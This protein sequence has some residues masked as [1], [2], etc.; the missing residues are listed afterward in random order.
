[1]TANGLAAA[2]W[3]L[4]NTLSGLALADVRYV[5]TEVELLTRELAEAIATLRRVERLAAAWTR[6]GQ[7]RDVAEC[8][9][10]VKAAIGDTG[11]GG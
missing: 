8:G 2:R 6:D 7:P 4:L 3:R 9:C 10:Q 11:G 1:M 5:L